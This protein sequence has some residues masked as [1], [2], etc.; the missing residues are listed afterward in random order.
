L[1]LTMHQIDGLG[2]LALP[3]TPAK[4]EALKSVCEQAPFGRGTSTVVDTSVR[5]T[6]QLGTD[7]FKIAATRSWLKTLSDVL[8][9]VCKGLGMPDGTRVEAQ[10][11]KLLVYEKGGFF[12]PHQ[13]TEKVSSAA[14]AVMV[15]NSTC[16]N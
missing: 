10:L 11:Y 14:A 16:A 5:N 1:L 2:Q 12:A 8:E 15:G 7:K 4:A 13:D 3:L 6:W 9:S